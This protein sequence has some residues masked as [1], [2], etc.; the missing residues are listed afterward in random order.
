MNDR[1]RLRPQITGAALLAAVLLAGSSSASAYWSV[2]NT[3][4]GTAT[5]GYT[6]PAPTTMSCTNQSVVLVAVARVS[7]TAVNGATGYRVVVTRA[8]G[9]V[10]VTRD[11]TTT[12]I[13]LSSG[14]LGDLLTGLLTPT[15]LT[16]RVAPI[17]NTG[18]G[19]WV[20]PNSRSYTANA[21]AV[22]IGT[23]CGAAVP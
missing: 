14:V 18:N 9:G 15:V 10:P 17:Y 4:T 3:H 1:R 8:S 2:S 20:S 13:D 5:A 23:T 19:I 12:S 7:W 16:V 6:A 22:P 11:V 21:S